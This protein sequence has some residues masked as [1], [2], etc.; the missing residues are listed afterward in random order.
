LHAVSDHEQE[1][2]DQVEHEL[3]RRRDHR[4]Q[5]DHKPREVHLADEV[6]PRE[7]RRYGSSGPRL[8]EP[9]QDDVHQQQHREVEG[10]AVEVDD[11]REHDVEHP[12]EQQRLH[13]RPD[14]AKRRSEIR[15]LELLLR[16]EP[17]QMDETSP[18]AADGRRPADLVHA[19][20]HRGQRTGSPECARVKLAA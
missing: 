1:H 8:E 3:H 7:D 18:S 9:E 13:E 10:A 14:V 2:D 12:E 19:Q 11:H 6:L 4:R 5:R 15:E 17:G 16:D 20:L